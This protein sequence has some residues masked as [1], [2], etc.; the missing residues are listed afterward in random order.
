VSDI[1]SVKGESIL[2][3]ACVWPVGFFSYYTSFKKY[4]PSFPDVKSCIYFKYA[5][6]IQNK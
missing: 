2:V 1:N 4:F 5:V 3:F 6:L